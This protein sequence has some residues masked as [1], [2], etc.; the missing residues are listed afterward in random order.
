MQNP[1]KSHTILDPQGEHVTTTETLYRLRAGEEVRLLDE[2][3]RIQAPKLWST[4]DPQVYTLKSSIWVD[5]QRVDEQVATFGI[6]E[7]AF[8]AREVLPK[9][10]ANSDEGGLPAS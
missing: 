8:T 3:L 2:L 10:R 7:A 9:W 1:R 5:G 6:R 4:E